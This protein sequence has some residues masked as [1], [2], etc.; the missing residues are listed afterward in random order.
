MKIAVIV[1]NYHKLSHTFIRLQV[2][3]LIAR[4]YQIDILS[5]EQV[6]GNRLIKIIRMLLEGVLT[7]G[8]L[9]RIFRNLDIRRALADIDSAFIYRDIASYDVIYCQ[10]LDYT[11]RLV[12][13]RQL[14]FI[15]S[16]VS[17]VSCVRGADLSVS[18]KL[19]KICFSELFAHFDLFLPVCGFLSDRLN[20]MGCPAAVQVVRSPVD[21]SQMDRFSS[22]MAKYKRIPGSPLRLLSVGRLTEKKGFDDAIAACSLLKKMGLP[23]IYHI[24]GDGGREKELLSAAR[25]LGLDT[26]VS[27]LGGMDHEE[28]LAAMGGYDMLLAPSKTASDG[29]CEGIPNVIKEAMY[30]GLQVVSTTHAGI[31]ELVVHGKT[32][33]LCREEAPEELAECVIE[34]ASD[35]EAWVDTSAQARQRVLEQYSPTETTRALE[36]VF[37]SLVSG[38]T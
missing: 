8:C 1:K 26:E 32:G 30:L 22:L 3:C 33:Y 19:E 13:L 31:A 23:F 18:K 37:D 36:R 17:L 2:E 24:I 28:L 20:S 14:G 35:T 12:R 38:R 11:P 34:L 4:G 10:F 21:V 6:P 9:L 29:N 15:P 5:P 7:P 16:C 25:G 27:L